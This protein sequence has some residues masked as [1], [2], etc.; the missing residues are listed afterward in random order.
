MA[1]LLGLL[2]VLL[3]C[4]AALDPALEEA[5]EGWKILHAKE[6]PVVGPAPPQASG[7]VPGLAPGG[8]DPEPPTCTHPIPC[9][10]APGGHF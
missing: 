6:Y 1:M 4:T 8:S 2:L 5:W 9:P 7:H 3:G 10:R